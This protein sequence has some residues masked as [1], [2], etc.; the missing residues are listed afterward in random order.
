MQK[1]FVSLVACAVFALPVAV[2]GQVAASPIAAGA[3]EKREDARERAGKKEAHPQ[4]RTAIRSLE[5]ARGEMQRA[6]HDFGG[7]RVE[8]IKAC[9][10]AL[11]QLR[12][13]LNYDKK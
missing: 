8:A 6:A 3:K 11:K 5:R 2:R 13:A 4:I 1:I 10:E 9:D 7:H 12:L